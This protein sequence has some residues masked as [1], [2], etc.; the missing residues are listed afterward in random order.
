M[1]KI[2]FLDFDGVLNTEHY[3]GLLQYQGKPWYY[4][5]TLTKTKKTEMI[6]IWIIKIRTEEE[7]EVTENG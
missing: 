4:S 1:N 5:K 2:L 6:I 3:Q 7:K